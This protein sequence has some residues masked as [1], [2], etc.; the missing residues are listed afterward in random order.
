MYM[1]PFV[2]TIHMYKNKLKNYIYIYFYEV[3]RA[4]QVIHSVVIANILRCIE[5]PVNYIYKILNDKRN[6][7]VL[8]NFLCVSLFKSYIAL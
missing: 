1:K 4:S 3:T 8:C 2:Y 5:Q 7:Q 6:T